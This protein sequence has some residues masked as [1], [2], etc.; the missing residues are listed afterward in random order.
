MCIR[1]NTNQ[2]ENQVR[3]TILLEQKDLSVMKNGAPDSVRC[4][5]D[6][7]GPYICEPATLGKMEARS[8][9][10]HRTV[11]CATGLSGE[12]AE[13]WLLVPTVDSAKCYSVQKCRDRIRSAEVRGHRTVRCGTR[14][15]GAAR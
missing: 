9:I 4:A 7:P 10:I 8:T 12:P 11:R 14:L 6:T 3:D 13:Q 15:S 5:P 1:F 2:E